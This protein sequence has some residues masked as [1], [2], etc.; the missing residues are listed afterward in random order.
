MPNCPAPA[1]SFALSLSA[2]MEH[3]REGPRHSHVVATA[4]LAAAAGL[5][6]LVAVLASV[7]IGGSKGRRFSPPMPQAADPLAPAGNLGLL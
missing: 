7:V 4:C 5:L 1:E 3:T 2:V 6:F